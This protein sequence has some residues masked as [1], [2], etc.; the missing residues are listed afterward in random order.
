MTPTEQAELDAI[1]DR[2]YCKRLSGTSWTCERL[3]DDADSL[4]A[5]I[6]LLQRKL[7]VRDRLIAILDDLFSE[8]EEFFEVIMLKQERDELDRTTPDAR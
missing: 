4:L 6:T 3:L 2:L 1:R 5:H 8:D 7:D